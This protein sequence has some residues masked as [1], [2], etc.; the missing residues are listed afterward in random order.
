MIVDMQGQGRVCK[1]VSSWQQAD[2]IEARGYGLSP[3]LPN[4]PAWDGI[5]ASS[6]NIGFRFVP[7]PRFWLVIVPDRFGARLVFCYN[8]L[9]FC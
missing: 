3:H 7:N 1:Q 4:G 9:M 5:H 6:Q 2:R 8:N